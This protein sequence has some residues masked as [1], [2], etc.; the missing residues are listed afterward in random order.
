MSQTGIRIAIDRGGTFTDAW[1]QIPGQSSDTIFKVLSECPDEYDDA[2]T[3]CIRQ[4]LETAA[5]S[6][7][8]RGTLLDL[9]PVESIRMGTTVATNTLLER[10]GERV[11]LLIT[12]GF[13]DLLKIGN[14]ARPN[15][16]DLSVQRLTQLYETVVEVDERV[17]IEGFSE[18]PEPKDIDIDS[19][20]E[21][22]LGL[23][24]E[25]VRVLRSPNLEEVRTGL[26]SLWEQGYRSVAVA[27]MHSYTYQE[28]EIAVAALARELGF[29]VAVS[30]ELQTMAKLV[31]RSQSA[32]AD[33]YLSPVTEKYL[34]GFRKGFKGGLQDEHAKKVFVNQSD[35][36]LT[37]IANFSGL[38]GV[39]SGPAGGVVGMSRTCYDPADGTPVL[40]FDSKFQFFQPD[41]MITTY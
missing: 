11:A 8:P 26:I 16:F 21:L 39:L 41:Q 38:R 3:E 2:P 36:G 31:P 14:Q 7:I 17:T 30:Y 33:A 5:G 37:S 20:A 18:D 22:R 28:H 15:I 34:D 23:T 29:K 12:K 32:V 40:A 13:R 19:D 24:G 27:L 6:P 35:G 1:A 9:T 10:K 25:V 4:I